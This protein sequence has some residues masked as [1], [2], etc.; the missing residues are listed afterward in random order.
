[1]VS[2]LRR[3]AKPRAPSGVTLLEIVVALPIV[4]LLL[5][6][7]ALLLIGAVRGADTRLEAMAARSETRR[8]ITMLGE[9]LAP[10]RQRDLRILSDTVLEVDAHVAVGT[11][12]AVVTP[13]QLLIAWSS[14]ASGHERARVGD[15][16][17]LWMPGAHP[18]DPP[19]AVERLVRDLR[20]IVAPSQPD[21]G[22]P[23]RATSWSLATVESLPPLLR[24]APVL[25][26]RQTRWV[27]YRSG[28]HWWIG[29]RT[30]V[31]G[32]WEP[33]QPVTG[34]TVSR[35]ERGLSISAWPRDAPG[36]AAAD[37]TVLVAVTISQGLAAGGIATGTV[38]VPIRDGTAVH[39]PITAAPLLDRA[40]R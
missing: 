3:G 14:V 26:R 2:P 9:L 38:L 27:H 40:P 29:Q 12:C 16:L 25:A 6:V 37:S 21:A 17:A 39:S 4:L 15:A 11:V 36:G 28:A 23:R 30:I 13:A 31:G 22:C 8:G 5:A 18:G 1:M 7:T 32:A 10:L 33:T 20:E 34:P 19:I 35:A 24:G